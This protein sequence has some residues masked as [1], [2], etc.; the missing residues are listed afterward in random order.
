M[1]RYDVIIAPCAAE[2]INEAYAWLSERN[3]RYAERWIEGIRT[4]ILSLDTLPE[5][6]ALAPENDAFEE[7][8]RQ[9]L[10]GR[11][12]PWRVF[13]TVKGS[14]VHVLHVHYGGRDAWRP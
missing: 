13:F 1:K 11:G 9:L 5:S 4:A 6:H 8:I 10:A 2:N 3:P 12:T 7:E 14:T